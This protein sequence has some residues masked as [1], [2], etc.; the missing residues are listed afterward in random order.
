MESASL[1]SLSWKL[2]E[3][4]TGIRWRLFFHSVV[5]FKSL[6]WTTDLPASLL[7][8]AAA[9]SNGCAAELSTNR[10]AGLVVLMKSEF[11]RGELV[12]ALGTQPP[13][14]LDQH[15]I[16]GRHA[17]SLASNWRCTKCDML[18]LGCYISKNMRFLSALR[19]QA[20]T[21]QN[22]RSVSQAGMWAEG[23]ARKEGELPTPEKT[24]RGPLLSLQLLTLVR[25]MP[26][27]ISFA[28]PKYR[29]EMGHSY[30]WVKNMQQLWIVKR[31]TRVL[32]FQGDQEASYTVVGHQGVF[33]KPSQPPT[34]PKPHAPGR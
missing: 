29:E 6:A 14:R 11:A 30:S 1:V 2:M 12:S 24:Q 20:V 28:G 19:E 18:Q 3:N 34:D 31:H 26:H 22:C 27:G 4:F 10:T 15:H 8:Q 32:C 5:I 33:L 7:S 23:K 13:V 25:L 16:P 17:Q 21:W 9:P